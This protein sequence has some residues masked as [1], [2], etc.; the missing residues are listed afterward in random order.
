MNLGQY[1]LEIERLAPAGVEVT[2]VNK[3]D[4]TLLSP[5]EIL[6]KGALS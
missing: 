1:R 3:M 6:G 5:A 2:G 4:S